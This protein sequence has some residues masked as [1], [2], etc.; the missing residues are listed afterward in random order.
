[1]KPRILFAITLAVPAIALACAKPGNEDVHAPQ[2]NAPHAEAGAPAQA[3]SSA[4]SACCRNATCDDKGRIV[5]KP[6]GSG[7][8]TEYIYHPRSGKLILI[9]DGSQKTEYHYNDEGHLQRAE[10]SY[11]KVITLEYAG[12]SQIRRMVQI[13]R[14]TD[15]RRDFTFKY[16]AA[17]KPVEIVL[18]GV[19]KVT[20]DYDEMG[21]IK[22]TRSTRGA[23]MAIQVSQ[24]FQ[25]LSSLVR[26]TGGKF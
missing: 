14:T 21:E 15:E 25:T 12:S 18:A 16:N 9:L 1:M 4:S 19:G 17:G 6:N 13:D 11:G 23:K 26:P 10:N 24:A 3:V 5:R 22:K 20:V 8:F 7:G 2:H